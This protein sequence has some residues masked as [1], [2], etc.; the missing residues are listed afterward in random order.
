MKQTSS[1][2]SSYLIF[3]ISR[4]RMILSCMCMSGK[5]KSNVTINPFVAVTF[6]EIANGKR[7]IETSEGKTSVVVNCADPV[8]QDPRKVKTN[9]QFTFFRPSSSSTHGVDHSLELTVLSECESHFDGQVEI[10]RV[11]V[12]VKA[13]MYE[14]HDDLYV[15][16]TIKWYVRRIFRCINILRERER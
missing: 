7:P 2:S 9:H 14:G 4:F 1:L 12:P 3:C 11:Q 5:E 15:V 6:R 16:N 13:V 10:G 8:W